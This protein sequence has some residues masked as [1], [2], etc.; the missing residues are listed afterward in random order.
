MIRVLTVVYFLCTGFLLIGQNVKQIRMDV[1][2]LSSDLC[3]GR[4]PGTKG[5]ALAGEYISERMASIGL[6]PGGTEGWYQPF[7]QSTKVDPHGGDAAGTR[8]INGKNVIGYLN[9]GAKYTIVIGA[10]YDHLGFGM[11]GGS[12][13]AE[14]DSSIH[15]GADDNASG[16]SCMLDIAEQLKKRGGKEFNYLFIGFSGE[17]EGLLGSKYWTH[18]PTIPLT[19]ITAMINMD[20]V[21]R[22]N[23]EKTLVIQ[24]TGTSPVWSTVLD[25]IYEGGVHVKG[26]ESGLGPSDHASFYLEGIPVLFLFTGQHSDYH[27]PSDDAHLIHYDGIALISNI[28]MKILTKLE[29]K[30]KL[31]F[32]MTKDGDTKKSTSF[33][34][35]LGVMP[36]YTYTGKG[37][38]IDGVTD[39]R[40]AAIAGL[41]KGDV[42][43]HLGDVE[44][45]DIYKYMEALAK[46][47]KGESAELEFLREN[48]SMKKKVTF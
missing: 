23:E 30:E 24:G 46:Y 9:Q 1:V 32:T 28:V 34:V 33:K 40:P 41:Q 38:R 14:R 6:E 43:I 21:G 15:N 3:M 36:D 37:M 20:M 31:P 25:T 11:D 17:E 4:F 13:H 5:E 26:A 22:L 7:E 16:V 27:K 44:V 2:Y 29:G 35:T 8:T 19:N 48:K 39:G 10:H 42:I 12:L 18:H 45:V 47:K